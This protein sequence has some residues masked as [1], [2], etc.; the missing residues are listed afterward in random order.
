MKPG[1]ISKAI[2]FALLLPILVWL[3]Y[4]IW[5]HWPL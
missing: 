4:A 3:A 5:A 2:V 1:D